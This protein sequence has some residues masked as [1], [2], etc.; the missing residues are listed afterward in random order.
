M[1]WALVLGGA[2]CVFEDAEKAIQLL[3]EPDVVV[4]VK[5]IWIEWPKVDH[6]ATYHIERIPRELERRRSLG[7]EDPKCIWTYAHIR[8]LKMPLPQ[9]CIKMTGGSSGLL[10]AYVAIRVADKGVLAGIPLD[11][12]MSHFHNR[13]Q[14]K[15][16]KEGEHY[17]KQWRQCLPDL[18]DRIK[19]MSGYTKELLGEPT[20]EWLQSDVPK[21][22]PGS[23]AS[24][25]A[26]SYKNYSV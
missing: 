23:M 26:P 4:A 22:T 6:V 1:T 13:K 7:Y 15:P 2:K 3:G 16:W 18:K 12:T 11:P 8:Q 5:D 10:G 25:R 9:K 24:Y 21:Y 20:V 14:G 19:S 17:M